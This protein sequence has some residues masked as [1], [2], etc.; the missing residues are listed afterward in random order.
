MTKEDVLLEHRSATAGL[1]D[2]LMKLQSDSLDNHISQLQMLEISEDLKVSTGFIRGV[3][4]FYS[5]L[6][7]QPRGRHVIRI[8]QSP[9]CRIK[10]SDIVLR[11]LE[12]ELGIGL[13]E[14]TLDGEFTLESSS[15]LGG[16]S[17][18]PAVQVDEALY[19]GMSADQVP[20]ILDLARG[21]KKVTPRRQLPKVL[22]K[23]HLLQSCEHLKLEDVKTDSIYKALSIAIKEMSPEL[24][25][26]EIDA[27]GLRG[28]GGAGFPT[29]R[30]WKFTRSAAGDLKYIVCNADEGEPGTF[31]DRLLLEGCPHLVIEGMILA[32]YAVGASKGFIYIRGEY[33]ESIALM[34]K[35]LEEAREAGY[36]GDKILGSTFSFDIEVYSGAGA[37]VCGEETSLLESMEGKRGFPR[38][39][40]PYPAS[41]GLFGKP[42][43]IN[44]VETLANVPLIVRD[45]SNAYRAL[46][47]NDASGS[48]LY[49][50]SGA[51][52]NT[53]VAEA[54]LGITL[55]ELIYHIGGGVAGSRALS[56]VL[57]GGAAGVFLG[58]D[59]LDV[60]LDYD[61]LAS[62]GAVLGSGAILVIDEDS[63]PAS[64]VLDIL[65]FFAHESCGQCSPCRVGTAR[66]LELM[67]DI[68][69]SKRTSASTVDLMLQT[70]LMMQKTSLCPL[71]QSLYPMLKSAVRC[72][73]DDLGI[74]KGDDA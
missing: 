19:T 61:S 50:L 43:V 10:G 64:L 25:L 70:A 59:M 42:T 41:V 66:L 74:N 51:L 67:E 18:P 15:C 53:G 7:E 11:R 1:V 46:G 49:P 68:V 40:P 56:A 32:G 8:C 34:E 13:G 23:S 5:M 38:V 35:A 48:K 12:T 36:L 37:Y 27:S 2:R 24:V 71:G 30:K 29:S 3:A 16:C 58:K 47:V 20:E 33:S 69:E 57:V 63:Q 73:G 65:R 52:T 17:A 26:E 21:K 22:S 45:G 31:K 72:F 28:R 60:P 54:P 55:R 4:T 14:T 39:R 9:N 44:N 62:H 6:S